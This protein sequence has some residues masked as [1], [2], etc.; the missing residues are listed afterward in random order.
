MIPVH[1]V[2]ELYYRD[3]WQNFR[4]NVISCQY[5]SWNYE[6]Q[7]PAQT[8]KQDAVMEKLLISVLPTA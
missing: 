6:G 4:N 5:S 3:K 8:L 7:Y 1:I 2:N